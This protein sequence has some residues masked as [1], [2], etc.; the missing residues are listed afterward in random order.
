MDGQDTKP[1]GEKTRDE[2]GVP[3]SRLQPLAYE[4]TPIL[5]AI[6]EENGRPLLPEKKADAPELPDPLQHPELPT[7]RPRR[8]HSAVR[9]LGNLFFFAALFLGGV[10]L[11]MFLRSR[12]AVITPGISNDTPN[13]GLPDVPVP[14]DVPDP[15][16]GWVTHGVT[17]GVTG[18]TIPGVGFRLPEDVPPPSCDAR[19]ASQGTYLPGGTRFTVAA[20][21][22]GQ[23][24]P[25][26]RGGRLVDAGGRAFATREAT[27]SGRPV[28]EYSGDFTGTTA[29]GFSFSRMRG[30]FLQ[31]TEDF[32]LEL[33]HFTPVGS[34]A[35][36][37]TDDALFDRIV[38]SVS[39]TGPPVPTPTP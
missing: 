17:N 31:L 21:G 35:D 30:I 4:E 26:V 12:L 3:T 8:T 24:L 2:S 14:T 22:K 19:C 34:D 39:F 9:F 25:F 11:S 16:A 29:G 18:E 32:A 10:F 6:E 37:V 36:F 13:G 33:N 28:Y 38:S 7:P 27:I 1:Q 5:T 20:R 23:V 15:F